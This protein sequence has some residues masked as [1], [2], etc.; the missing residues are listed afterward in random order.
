MLDISEMGTVAEEIDFLHD[1]A[2]KRVGRRGFVA[3]AAR[4]NLE[5][6]YR[7]KDSNGD[8]SNDIMKMSNRSPVTD[9]AESREM[10]SYMEKVFGW[11]H[12]SSSA[13]AEIIRLF[14]LVA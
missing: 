3:S 9:H 1:V 2:T 12:L 10:L 13:V 4:K 6:L 5:R 14:A 8:S 11:V 7:N